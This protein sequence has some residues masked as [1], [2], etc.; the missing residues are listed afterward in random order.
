M[1]IVYGEGPT[2]ARIMV[3]GES[4]SAE[5]SRAHRPFVG[6]TGREQDAHFT[7]NGI[8][9]EELYLT[10]LYKKQGGSGPK[11]NTVLQEEIN[12]VNPDIIVAVGD[13]VT[14]HLTGTPSLGVS[15]GIAQ[16]FGPEIIVIPVY[17]PGVY[18]DRPD[19]LP[20]I[21]QDYNRVAGVYK[22]EISRIT[23]VDEYPHP[24]YIEGDDR[25]LNNMSMFDEITIDT[26]G[27]PGDF[28]SFQ[29]SVV[30]G[31]GVVFRASEPRFGESLDAFVNLIRG[32]TLVGHNLMYE[33]EMF[34]SIGV[35]LLDPSLEIKLWDTMLA[36]YIMITES[37][38]LKTL[39]KRW[40]GMEMKSYPDM[41]GPVG[42]QK[43]L[44]YLE[45][46]MNTEWPKPEDRIKRSNNGSAKLY[47]P[48]PIGRRA[49][50][51]LIDVY[52]EKKDKEGRVADPLK[53]WNKVDAVL[54][55][56]VEESLGPMP[57]GTL[58]DI[59]L[60]EAI[61]YSARDTDAT[62]RLCHRLR[63]EISI[64][65]L[66]D[67]MN[68]K[69][70]MLPVAS[71]MRIN[72]FTARRAHFEE[73]AEDL[74]QKMDVLGDDLSRRFFKG[75]PF[76]PNST[77]DVRKMMFRKGLMGS[78]KTK[79]GRKPSTSKKSIEHLRFDNPCIEMVETWREY[80]KIR[81]SFA[82]P[83]MRIIPEKEETWRIQGNIKVASVATGRFA[84]TNPP[85]MAIPARTSLGQ[86]V[87][88]GFVAAEGYVLG[89]WDLDQVEMRVM[90]D[91]SKDERLV[92][93]FRDGTIDIHTD[94][95]SKIFNIPYE[96]VDKMDHRYPAKRAGFG[97]IT[98]I[99]AP[100]LLDQLRM[101]GCK[102]WTLE[103]VNMLIEGWFDLYPGVAKYMVACREECKEN[104]GV[105]T[106]RWGMA[107]H[108]P[109]IFSDK[110]GVQ[111]EAERQT[112]S[113]RIQG[114]AQ[115]II[116]NAMG[117]LYP[118]IRQYG[119][120]VRWLLQVHDE[121]IVEC[122]E[123][124]EEIIGPLMIEGLEKHGADM[125]IPITAGGNFAKE[126]GKLK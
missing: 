81:D 26:E 83:I 82:T 110:K 60:E 46:V 23:A 12:R 89:A 30:Y 40:C 116:Q 41:V 94:T 27:T 122:V 97:V 52:S 113:H 13:K 72:G 44:D 9:R 11:W 64:A 112:H 16:E 77:A 108:L 123:G 101:A 79:I 88:N 37:K 45:V 91:E 34:Q 85:M 4:P 19:L 28:W 47:K 58:S 74:Q 90:A 73:M 10:Y 115:G 99:Q 103:K 121:L 65:G 50:V 59:P 15:H 29:V 31:E 87:R 18:F 67:L 53:R 42:V 106:D 71:E 39:A 117:W 95:A 100:G 56:M 62:L 114:G 69:M 86:E 104:G 24:L 25:H 2:N 55:V 7:R 119:D 49:E 126:W 20:L 22:G 14:E 92:E 76:N 109:G 57:I 102:R 21:Q 107:R 38:G 1:A 43:Q 75:D 35:D 96:D 66:N 111:L 3:V 70:G 32:K 118:R 17:D 93:L 125:I 68:M 33:F 124:M 98:G 80:S 5:D 48:Q 120:A 105:V 51:I 84:M 6:R 78:K 54:K 63:P 61:Y 36:A 8:K